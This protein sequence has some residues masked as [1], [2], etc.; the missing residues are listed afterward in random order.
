M[1]YIDAIRSKLDSNKNVFI[2]YRGMYGRG[3][4]VAQLLY[5]HIL[6]CKYRELIPF[7]APLCNKLD[8]FQKQSYRAIGNCKIFVAIF[9]KDFFEIMSEIPAER[10][11]QIDSLARADFA[12]LAESFGI[13]KYA[14]NAAEATLVFTSGSEGNPKAA[15]LTERNLIANCLQTKLCGLFE[16]GDVFMANLPIFHS[17]GQLFEVWYMALHGQYTVTL[18]NPLDIKNNIRA[19]RE[20]RIAV[21]AAGDA[22]AR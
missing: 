5:H 3:G 9:T 7:C 15:V 1:E 8:D 4:L 18:S 6:E 21:A 2:C 12:A 14:D 20:N 13:E 10:I 16:E 17:F 22:L 11:G 19:I